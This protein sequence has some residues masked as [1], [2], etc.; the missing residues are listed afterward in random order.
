MPTIVLSTE[1]VE[2][3][4]VDCLFKEGEDTSTHIAAEGIMMTVGF[5]P[6]R[7]ESHR[8]EIEAMLD[9]LPDQFKASSGGGWSFLNA[10]EDKHGN[11]WTSF[12]R[13]MD[14][15]FMLGMAIGKVESQMPRELWSA[16]PGGM[17][18]YVID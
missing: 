18:Y 2:K 4:F 15:L 13:S 1:G 7:I 3:V 5:H 14:Q 10:C 12:H 11:Q 6:E 8:A 9:E 17:P 16:L